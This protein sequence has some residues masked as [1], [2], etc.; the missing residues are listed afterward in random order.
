MNIGAAAKATGISAKMI[1]YYESIGLLPAPA[2]SPSGYRHYTD[3]DLNRLHF[4]RRGRDLGF[5]MA[6]LT[7]LL[8]LWRDQDRASAD[9]KH[10][11]EQHIDN[12]NQRIRQMQEMVATLSHLA[13]SCH[14]DDRPHCP[15]IDALQHPEDATGRR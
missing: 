7:E 1:R 5:S 13:R 8:S 11:A 12:M 4:I 10:I 9:V 14:G 15:I 2:R 6:Q 3:D